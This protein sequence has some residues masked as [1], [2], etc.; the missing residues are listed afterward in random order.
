[1]VMGDLNAA[2]GEGV[3]TIRQWWLKVSKGYNN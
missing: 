2:V 1:M 3:Q